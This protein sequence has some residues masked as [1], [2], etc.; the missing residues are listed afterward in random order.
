MDRSIN[1]L[2]NRGQDLANQV[3]DRAQ[4]LGNKGMDVVSDAAQQA[5]DVM[6]DASD[7]LIAYTK[8]N[9]VTALLIAAASGVL[10]TTLIKVLAPPRD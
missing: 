9:P 4:T 3:A 10:L 7:S 1:K 6:S 2:A 5:R 8:K